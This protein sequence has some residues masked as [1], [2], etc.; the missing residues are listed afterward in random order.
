VAIQ[1]GV[2]EGRVI[3]TRWTRRRDRAK[4]EENEEE[5]GEKQ[6]VV[7]KT[8]RVVFPRIDQILHTYLI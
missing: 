7:S 6:N 1:V 8:F 3:T 5:Y 4:G 2:W